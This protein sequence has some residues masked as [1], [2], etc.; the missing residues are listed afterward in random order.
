MFKII[1]IVLVVAVIGVLAFASTKPNTFHVA[2]S[3]VIKAPPEKIY[4][5]LD[6]FHRWR[7]WSPYEALDPAMARTYDGPAS[8]Q[9]AGYGWSGKGKAGAGRMEIVKAVSPSRLDI[10]LT[11]SKPFEAHHTAIFTL[12]PEGDGVRV[13]WAMEGA[14]PLMFKVMSLVFNMDRMI[15]TDFEAGLAKLKT[16]AEEG[17]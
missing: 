3:I 10:A 15:G 7:A 17:L 2:R 12:T 13:T 14:A 1:A 11:F 5:L 16:V 8:G 9:G 6:D 4:A